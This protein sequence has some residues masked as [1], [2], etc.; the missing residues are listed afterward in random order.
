MEAVDLGVPSNRTFE[1]AL[2]GLTQVKQQV[3]ED[4][5]IKDNLRLAE[6]PCSSFAHMVLKTGSD[7]QQDASAVTMD[8]ATSAGQKASFRVACREKS[9][10]SVS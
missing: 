9:H 1:I 5:R 10:N 7:A 6:Q 2:V 3:L 4:S 8:D